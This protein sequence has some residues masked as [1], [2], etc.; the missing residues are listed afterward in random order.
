MTNVMIYSRAEQCNDTLFDIHIFLAFLCFQFLPHHDLSCQY[1]SC[2]EC[3]RVLV[4]IFIVSV[5]TESPPEGNTTPRS[6]LIILLF[7]RSVLPSLTCERDL[8]SMLFLFLLR[9]SIV[10]FCWP[11]APKTPLQY[12]ASMGYRVFAAVAALV[13]SGRG[14]KKGDLLRNR[15]QD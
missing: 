14:Q 11:L 8:Q 1:Q 12:P 4:F 13:R 2:T 3:T 7:S 15:R 9:F 6:C 5:Q 10:L